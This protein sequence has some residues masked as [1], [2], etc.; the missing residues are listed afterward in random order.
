M[1]TKIYNIQ[2][3]IWIIFF[4]ILLVLA[5]L[6]YIFYIK[7]LNKNKFIYVWLLII[8]VIN[9]LSIRYTFKNY[10]STNERMGPE[11]KRGLKGVKGKKG[12]NK[13]CGCIGNNN[14][15]NTKN[16]GKII[17]IKS[18]AEKWTDLILSY[19]KGEEFLENHFYVEDKWEQLLDKP[20]ERTNPFDTI[21][22]SK[23]WDT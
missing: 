18:E 16:R 14:I 6:A 13:L 19:N 22:T 10:L 2:L 1:E 12:C 7:N 3:E 11:G 15:D 8:F 5:L 9:I 21:K 20:R 4:N 17:E 23:Y